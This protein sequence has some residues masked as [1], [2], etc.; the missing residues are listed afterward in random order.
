MA[1]TFICFLGVD[2]LGIEEVH[3]KT[4]E[5]LIL[6]AGYV[7]VLN[8]GQMMIMQ[9][10]DYD[11]EYCAESSLYVTRCI[12]LSENDQVVIRSFERTFLVYRESSQRPRQRL[13]ASHDPH[14]CCA[15]LDGWQYCAS[16]E[17]WVRKSAIDN[18]C[19]ICKKRTRGALWPHPGIELFK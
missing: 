2:H 19:P 11:Y 16:Y 18:V 9:D 1:K 6:E 5:D 14:Y 12:I 8:S 17:L 3:S 10:Q 7:L 15:H 4:S 13:L